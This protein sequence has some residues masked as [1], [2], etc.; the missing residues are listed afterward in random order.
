MDR[1]PQSADRQDQLKPSPEHQR[2]MPRNDY[3]CT[4]CGDTAEQVHR[5]AD[6]PEPCQRCGGAVEWAAFI[7]AVK[8][9][10]DMFWENEN[11]GKGHY[12]SQLQRGPGVGECD[13]EAFCR[14]QS[15]A[16]EKCKKRGLRVERTR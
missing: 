8:P 1:R 9:P 15:E 4:K 5:M 10:P 6:K 7:P 3:T 11:G 14:S 13:R 12:I 2:N 16:I